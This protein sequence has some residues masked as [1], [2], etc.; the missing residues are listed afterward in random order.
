MSIN[1]LFFL[2]L[3]VLVPLLGYASWRNYKRAERKAQYDLY[4]LY[5]DR[6]TFYQQPKVRMLSG[7]KQD[8]SK[9]WRFFPIDNE[10]KEVDKQ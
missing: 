3:F 9:E 8:P 6:E 2:V 7:Q 1:T 10:W 5:H 4:R